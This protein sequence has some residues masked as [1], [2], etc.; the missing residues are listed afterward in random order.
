MGISGWRTKEAGPKINTSDGIK[1]NTLHRK[2][3][4][5]ENKMWEIE[6]MIGTLHVATKDWYPD[7]TD[8]YQ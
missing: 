1:V 5:E 3:E 7:V 8:T 6:E 4:S 2:V